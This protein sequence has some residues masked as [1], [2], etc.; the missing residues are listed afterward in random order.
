VL[1]RSNMLSSEITIGIDISEDPLLYRTIHHHKS[2]KL[3]TIS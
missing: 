3:L 2:Q 1:F